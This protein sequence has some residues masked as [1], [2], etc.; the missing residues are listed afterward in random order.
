MTIVFGF[1]LSFS[2][3]NVTQNSPSGISPWQPFQRGSFFRCFWF[4]T[5]RIHLLLVHGFSPFFLMLW[6]K[7]WDNF[8]VAS[9]VGRHH[10]KLRSANFEEAG[11][12]EHWKSVRIGMMGSSPA[13]LTF[14]SIFRSLPPWPC[15]DPT[16]CRRYSRACLFLW[17]FWTGPEDGNSFNL[18]IKVV[19]KRW[20][21]LSSKCWWF[22]RRDHQILPVCSFDWA[23]KTIG[24]QETRHEEDRSRRECRQ[25]QCQQGKHL[26]FLFGLRPAKIV[27]KSCVAK[28][29]HLVWSAETGPMTW[30][31]EHS[32]FFSGANW[33]D[34]SWRKMV[35]CKE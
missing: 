4:S 33:Q 32:T 22:S 35:Y 30:R 23:T 19:T 28:S 7:S 34:E 27:M 11:A 31:S 15:V 24:A 3:S 10:H 5:S 26:V 9:V 8:C 14:S 29:S 25:F 2:K 17:P 1:A 18:S 20:F 21:E 6:Q 12:C 16:D 13:A